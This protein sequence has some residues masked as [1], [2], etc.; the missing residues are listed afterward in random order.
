LISTDYIPTKK[1]IKIMKFIMNYKR[2][3]KRSP[4]YRE[5]AVHVNLKGTN[6]INSYLYRLKRK[7]YVDFIPAHKRSVQVIKEI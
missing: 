5:I 2:T 7:G 4:S 1:E 3:E 6:S